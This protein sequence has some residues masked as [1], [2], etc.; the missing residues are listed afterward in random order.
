MVQAAAEYNGPVYLRLGRLDVETVLD[1]SYDFQIGIANTLREGNDVT[2]VSTGLLT[3]EAL[4]A[5]DELAKENISVRVVNCGTIKPLDGETILK[6]AK[7]TKFIITAEEHSVIGGL[8]SAVSEVVVAHKPVPMEFVGVK[9]TF[10]RVVHQRL[11]AK[12]GLT[13]DDIVK[14]VKKVVTRK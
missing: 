1:D 13:A 5:T 11:M 6:A 4:K 14:A 7:E 10:G 2:I 3:Q 9:D 12:Y 8:G